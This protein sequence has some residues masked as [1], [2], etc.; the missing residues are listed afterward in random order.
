[1]RTT[2]PLLILLVAGCAKSGTT[3][4]ASAYEEI[5]QT[6]IAE[7][8]AVFAEVAT[9]HA[10]LADI[11]L[12]LQGSK[13]DVAESLGLASDTDFGTALDELVAQAQGNLEVTMD[14][15][16]PQVST[17]AEAPQEVQDA[18]AA[19]NAGLD[20]VEAA[21]AKTAELP[22]QVRALVEKAAA[23]PE[24]VDKD[25]LSNN[26][27]AVTEVLSVAKTTKS[28]L[29]ATR[30]TDDRIAAVNQELTSYPKLVADSL[31]G[32][33]ATPATDGDAADDGGRK[34]A[35]G[36]EAAD[37]AAPAD[38]DAGDEATTEEA[39]TEAVD[40]EP[41][42]EEASSGPDRTP[43]EEREQREDGSGKPKSKQITP[44]RKGK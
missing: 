41:A 1:M 3:D 18:V 44:T 32:A 34:D 27:V 23:F 20:D 33:A 8:D 35:E 31:S 17:S 15:M 14:G 28:N 10:T 7:F 21:V 40:E 19:L 30:A 42:S 9:I 24:Q 36:D 5:V 29:S 25:L 11:E 43:I 39:D 2:L 4:A 26:D 13:A 12:D 38:A 37:V 6:G 22:A 16:T